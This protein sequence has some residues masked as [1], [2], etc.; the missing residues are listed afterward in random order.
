MAHTTSKS[1][2]IVLVMSCGPFL[3]GKGRPFAF[4]VN[5]AFVSGRAPE[6]MGDR[7]PVKVRT[8]TIVL[9]LDTCAT[10]W[11]MRARPLFMVLC[12]VAAGESLPLPPRASAGGGRRVAAV[13][14]ECGDALKDQA[15]VGNGD[16]RAEDGRSFEV[17]DAE[18]GE[19]ILNQRIGGRHGCAA[20]ACRR[21]LQV[22]HSC[23]VHCV[24]RQSNSHSAIWLGMF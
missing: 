17:E 14:V 12:R 7:A 16:V 3:F 11:A 2:R 15:A 13:P 1:L 4:A 8:P 10:M 5:V 6:L 20:F 23:A 19:V 9:G 18:G 22:S 21:Q 24:L